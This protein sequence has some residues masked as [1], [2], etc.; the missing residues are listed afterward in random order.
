MAWDWEDW[1]QLAVQAFG[2][3]Q[4]GQGAKDAARAQQQGSTAGIAEQRRQFDLIFG[5]LQP[6]YQVGTQALNDLSR[7]FGYQPAGSMQP[8]PGAPGG[9]T[10]PNA[11]SSLGSTGIGVSPNGGITQGLQTQG[12]G[13]VA[14]AAGTS[15]SSIYVNPVYDRN[16][17]LM[18]PPAGIDER[19]K[20]GVD[21][22]GPKFWMM[23]LSPEE[24]RFAQA[25]DDAYGSRS[26]ISRIAGVGL[27]IV[28][29]AF[30]A[31]GAA[32]ALNNAANARPQYG[33]AGG[34]GAPVGG[35]AGSTAGTPN[36][37]YQPPQGGPTGLANFQASPDYEFRR[38]EGTRGVE[39]LFS[40]RGGARSGNAL[41]ALADFNSG[42]AS[43]EFTNYFNR[44]AA[45]A[46][47][48]QTAT[49]QAS[50]L[51]QNTGANV[52][53]LLGQ[54]GNARA[55]GIAGQTNALTGGISDFLSWWRNQG[56][57]TGGPA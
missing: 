34:N 40:A 20:A 23:Y 49:N 43:N 25:Y 8:A 42:L 44:R 54:A 13:P 27:D 46:G 5:M 39:N 51:A 6:Q 2:S 14:P 57:A 45:L 24:Q 41:R 11:G 47:I 10:Q 28:G 31:F 17:N 15:G 12:A 33:F 29:T 21:R 1:A 9:A 35:T 7:T 26:D 4:E 38:N 50:S 16:G 56:Q 53:N 55:S 30:P 32:L 19:I 22:L 52:S 37:T 3:Y 36:M 48:G 18:Q